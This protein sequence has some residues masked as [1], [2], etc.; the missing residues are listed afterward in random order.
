VEGLDEEQ[1]GR[2]EIPFGGGDVTTIH[3]VMSCSTATDSPYR[4]PCVRALEG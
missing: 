3:L 2:E 4:T 1:D